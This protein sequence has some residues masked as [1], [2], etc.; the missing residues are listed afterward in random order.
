MAMSLHR[1]ATNLVAIGMVVLFL[2]AVPFAAAQDEVPV[3]GPSGEPDVEED[4][5]EPEMADEPSGGGQAAPFLH[6]G[7]IVV[8]AF[9]PDGKILATGGTRG[10]EVCLWDPATGRKLRELVTHGGGCTLVTFSPDG[11]LLASAGWDGEVHLWDPATGKE[12]RQV[13]PAPLGITGLS[14]SPDGKVL[15]TATLATRKGGYRV[16]WCDLATG[17]IFREAAGPLRAR[18]D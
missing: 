16:R 14:F 12:V 10:G 9:S 7:P 1:F 17:K 6:S 3:A 11:R 5:V 13:P 4:C 2:V 8:A 15:A 18:S